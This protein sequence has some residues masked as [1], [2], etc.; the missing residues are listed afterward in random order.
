MANVATMGALTDLSHAL[1][2]RLAR[3]VIQFRRVVQHQD[4]HGSRRQ[5]HGGA[6][7]R[8]GRREEVDA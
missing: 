1:G 2:E 4:H 7:P 3:G 6:Y 8:R 5:Q